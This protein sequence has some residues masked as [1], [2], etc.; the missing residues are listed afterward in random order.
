[1]TTVQVTLSS[2]GQL[3]FPNG[4]IPAGTT[5]LAGQWVFSPGLEYV[6]AVP[7]NGI[8]SLYQVLGPP[9]TNS[10]PV[11][12]GYQM[13]QS[14]PPGG[15]HFAISLPCSLYVNAGGYLEAKAG[16]GATFWQSPSSSTTPPYLDVQ[17]DGNLVLYVPDGSPDG[18]AIWASGTEAFGFGNFITGLGKGG[19]G[20]F[21]VWIEAWHN[22]ND[23]GNN[24]LAP[25]AVL[26]NTTLEIRGGI[27][28]DSFALGSGS[29]FISLGFFL[30]GPTTCVVTL[31][32]PELPPDSST[33]SF[34]SGGTWQ[35]TAGG[36]PAM[37]F[38]L[39]NG[40]TISLKN[41]SGYI[42]IDLSYLGGDEWLSFELTNNDAAM[43]RS[44]RRRPGTPLPQAAARARAIR[45]RLLAPPYAAHL[46]GRVLHWTPA[47][48]PGLDKLDGSE[49]APVLAPHQW[50]E[51]YAE[52]RNAAPAGAGGL[53]SVAEVDA[54][55]RRARK[56]GCLPIAIAHIRYGTPDGTFARSL[57]RHVRNGNQI[58]IPDADS[59]RAHTAF[60]AAPLC[61][62]EYRVLRRLPQVH[63][64]LAVQY[65]VPSDLV[66]DNDGTK[67]AGLE[68]DFGDGHGFRPVILDE[69]MTVTYAA[70]GT[71]TIRVRATMACGVLAAAGTL[72]VAEPTSPV[73]NEVWTLSS[74]TSYQG[75][76]ATGY[77]FVLY[78]SG[79]SALTN[80]LLLAEG[81]PGGYS[82]ETLWQDFNSQNLAQDLLGMGYDLVIV[83]FDDGTSYVEANAGVMV[84][85]IQRAISETNGTGSLIVGGAS[86]GGLVAR[87]ALAYMETNQLPHNTAYYV[88]YDTPHLGANVPVS[89]Q[90]MIQNTYAL[91]GDGSLEPVVTL[92]NSP[93]AQEMLIWWVSDMGG[94]SFQ[95]GVS[96]E[97][98][99]L[100][101]NLASIGNFPRQPVLLGVA[102]GA[103][104]GTLNVPSPASL[105]VY[106]SGD[107]CGI[108]FNTDLYSA[109]GETSNA[110]LACY[111]AISPNSP[112]YMDF[113]PVVADIETAPG[114]TEPFFKELCMQLTDAGITTNISCETACFVPTISALSMSTLSTNNNSDLLGNV[115]QVPSDLTYWTAASNDQ[116]IAITPQ[117]AAW[118]LQQIPSKTS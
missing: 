16:N 53:P 90:S 61:A 68:I 8:P 14:L 87:Y 11:F 118:L 66:L 103:A 57:L 65:V 96:P 73:P 23:E 15:A 85:A 50:R 70:A 46:P 20:D 6:L 26:N 4:H 63:P 22:L 24:G 69:P 40:Y 12:T 92:L 30:T 100:I 36:D 48:G 67:P 5:L 47:R 74:S 91:L 62:Q 21:Y 1:M 76:M 9:P 10:N 83:C 88:S 72:T 111:V 29:G 106:A 37:V 51:Y 31:D 99:A 25:T 110:N 94:S 116:H 115:E 79:N 97:R 84:A 7:L 81:Y 45:E 42:E 55:A 75:V 102:D 27:Q 113:G 28:Y 13:W 93:A 17:G 98:T 80:P 89:L 108:Q 112:V 105:V 3:D 19:T 2:N 54:R 34:S 114:S 41:D 33:H 60:F 86:M 109:P 64:S 44:M 52:L 56:A 71:P 77:A 49:T 58:P 107:I 38:T 78:G 43:T 104:D 59:F 95:V 32:T 117:T 101:Q 18:A 35:G 82:L 39:D